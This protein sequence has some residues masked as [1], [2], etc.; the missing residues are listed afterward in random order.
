M[1]NRPLRLMV[2]VLVGMLVGAMPALANR[3]DHAYGFA[4]CSRFAVLADGSE[5]N[6][7][8]ATYAV[9]Y[10]IWVVPTSGSPTI[11]DGSFPVTDANLKF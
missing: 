8:G 3:L 11:V 4:D 10:R 2:L 7:P 9:A 1:L 6:V 5:L